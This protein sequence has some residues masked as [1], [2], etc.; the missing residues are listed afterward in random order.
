MAITLTVTRKSTCGATFVRCA[1]TLTA[2]CSDGER[3]PEDAAAVRVRR[4]GAARAGGPAPPEYARAEPF[5][6]VVIDNFLPDDVLR[7]VHDEWP[8]FETTEWTVYDNDRELEH[9]CSDL[10][11][12]G[13]ATQ[14]LLQAFNS[15]SFVRFVQVLTGITPLLVDPHFQAAGIFDVRP[16]G[17][18]D[19]HTDF[20]ECPHRF[21][22]SEWVP[23]F[24]DK[25]S[26]GAGLGGDARTRCCTS[27]PSGTRPTGAR[28][29]SGATSRSSRRSRSCRSGTAWWCSPLFPDAVH[30][31][32]TPVVDPP[33][34]SRK[35][36][37]AYYYT[38]ERPMRE[39]LDASTA[40]VQQ[41]RQGSH[42]RSTSF[43]AQRS[44]APADRVPRCQEDQSRLKPG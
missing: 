25:Y 44:A 13:S 23:N 26:G 34:G 28:S 19:L 11:R 32:P 29:S 12:L 43:G 21:S 40:D 30:G 38:K 36:L 41:R 1:R 42:G 16:G 15:S 37:S 24:W 27:T 20:T 2:R 35:C 6:H 7:Q 14:G 9:V 17:F 5:P 31:H 18:L 3:Q 33:G 39:I 22:E 10:D 4:R 8:D